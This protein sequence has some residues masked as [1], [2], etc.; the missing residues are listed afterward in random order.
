MT[1]IQIYN[2]L[3]EDLY[4]YDQDKLAG[5]LSSSDNSGDND[6]ESKEYQ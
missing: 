3:D 5:L 4:E 6:F 2:S 1:N